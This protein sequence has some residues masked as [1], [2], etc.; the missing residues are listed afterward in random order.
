MSPAAASRLRAC[1]LL[2][3]TALGALA[4]PAA[5]AAIGSC[6]VSATGVL[7]GTYTPVQAAPLASSGTISI[8]CTA[9]AGRNTITIDLSTGSSGNYLTRTLTSGGFTL[10]YDLYLDPANTQI[11]GDGTGGSV[12]GTAQIRRRR[13]N[14]T[15]T[16]YGAVAASQDPAP[17]SYTDSITVTVNY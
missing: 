1:A 16:V 6:T 9:V 11:W 17:G 4:S 8:A 7:F 3:C 13:P 15:L 2:L 10:N 12:E 14:A 5:R